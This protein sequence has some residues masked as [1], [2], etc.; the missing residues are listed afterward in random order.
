MGNLKGTVLATTKPQVPPSWD[1][2][3]KSSDPMA[4]SKQIFFYLFFFFLHLTPKEQTKKETKRLEIDNIED[5][6]SFYFI[7]PFVYR[8]R[9]PI[10]AQTPQKSPN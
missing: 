5:L 3:S 1:W 7:F 4:S 9:T 8:M 10:L 6:S 2:N